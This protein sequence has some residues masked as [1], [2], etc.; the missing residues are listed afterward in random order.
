MIW[1]RLKKLENKL[2]KFELTERDSYYYLFAFAITAILSNYLL[3]E[4]PTT[5]SVNW[6]D[7]VEYYGS[8]IITI[9]G[10]S[11]SFK[12]NESGNGKEYLKRF[13]SISWVV[14]VRLFL[15]LIPVVMLIFIGFNILT[16]TTDS[17]V[18]LPESNPISDYLIML[19]SLI[20]QIVF[21]SQICNS[22]RRI[23]NAHKIL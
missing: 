22:F 10:L 13:L 8:I 11:N 7:R 21:F 2:E 14:A 15:I 20:T 4:V 19:I 6:I 23:N 17:L 16:Y 1:L 12:I 18:D 5:S 9:W 3:N